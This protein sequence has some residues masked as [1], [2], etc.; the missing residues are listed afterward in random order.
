[1]DR[2]LVSLIVALLVIIGGVL[3]AGAQEATP[4]AGLTDLSL[5]QLEVTVTATA[6]EGV[7]EQLEAGRY[8]LRVSAAEDVEFG[9]YVALVQPAG[10][11]AEE[12]LA[13]LSGSPDAGAMGTPGAMPE[14]TPVDGGDEME[15][16]GGPPPFIFEAT[17][18][19]GALAPTGQSTEVVLDLTPGQWIAWGEDP[20][21]PQPPVIFDVTG[22]MPADLPEP[23][24]SATLTMAEYVIEVSEGELR[25]GSQLVKIENVGA[26]PHFI[27]VFRGPDDMTAEQV[28]VALDEEMAA[29]ESGTPVAYSGLNPDEDLMPVV[30]TATQSTGTTMWQS[31]DL[32]PGTYGIACFFPD[33]ESGI[34]HVYLGMWTVVEVAE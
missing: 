7:P 14:G 12:F 17:Y 25:A 2:R 8:L 13:A 1:M 31:M 21:A 10:M 19:G 26:Q 15:K 28:G 34:P 9:G 20:A 29:M 18:A 23:E 3:P 6:I 24:S 16:M 22:E 11:S 32:E 4:V 27:A 5:P 33:L 30:F